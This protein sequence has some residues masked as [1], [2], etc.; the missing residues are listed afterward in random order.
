[1]TGNE[2][3][4][5]SRWV[6]PCR[7]NNFASTAG[8]N[9][10]REYCCFAYKSGVI[11]EI[12]RGC[13]CR[14]DEV[15]EVAFFSLWLNWPCNSAS[16]LQSNQK[17]KLRDSWVTGEPFLLMIFMS[18]FYDATQF[19]KRLKI[20]PLKFH[21]L[22]CLELRNFISIKSN[23]DFLIEFFNLLYVNEICE[24]KEL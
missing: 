19:N 17:T 13:K 9:S 21:V 12:E 23:S 3:N 6:G 10:R 15:S 20:V 7:N 1:M 5:A 8:T 24:K 4:A 22:F 16:I 2:T 14:A 18:H 11:G